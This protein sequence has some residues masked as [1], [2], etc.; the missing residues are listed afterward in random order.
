MG[1]GTRTLAPTGQ[2]LHVVAHG[3]RWNPVPPVRW[4]ADAALIR[5]GS[6][7]GIDWSRFVAEARRR[8]LTARLGAGLGRLVDAIGFPVP[9]TVVDELR[10]T[11]TTSLER[12]AQRA[13]TKPVGG[14]SWLPP[15]RD[16]YVR[17]ARL[18]LSLRLTAYAHEFF[19]TSSS[20]A[21]AG[22]IARKAAAVTAGQLALRLAPTRVPRC[23]G[24]AASW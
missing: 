6:A 20:L 12:W 4:I 7:D 19:G 15:V 8:R 10:R 24:C 3:G 14:E 18:D 23:A 16:E 17:R 9:A 21:L 22:R 13:A 2:L 1:V 11:A 5:R